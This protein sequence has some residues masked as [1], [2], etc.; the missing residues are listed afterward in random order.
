MR[1]SNGVIGTL[2]AGWVDVLNTMPV[3]VAGTE[4]QVYVNDGQVYFKS[5]HVEGADGKSAWTDLPAELPHAFELFFDAL[6]GQDVPLISVREAA[7][8]TAVME[9]FYEAAASNTWVE[10]Q[11]E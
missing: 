9:A 3:L 5:D 4:G 1:F 10:P 6:H 7:D 11:T 8:R 2:A